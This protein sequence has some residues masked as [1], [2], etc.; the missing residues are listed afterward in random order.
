MVFTGAQAEFR[1]DTGADPSRATLYV[2]RD[3]P[4]V[5]A[6]ELASAIAAVPGVR[7]ADAVAEYSSEDRATLYVAPCA[8]LRELAALASCA[9]GDAFATRNAGAPAPAFVRGAL[10]TVDTRRDPGGAERDG[11]FATPG[12]LRRTDIAP[13]S[14]SAF[15]RADP[16]RLDVIE[17]VRNAAADVDPLLRV[18]VL[19]RTRTDGQFA[20]LRRAMLA[21]ASIVIGLIGLSLLL[22]ALE[23]L[24]ERRRLLAV[25]VAFGTRRS[26]LSWSLLWQSAVPIGLGLSIAVLTG[27]GL[28]AVLLRIIGAGV[29]VAWADVAAMVV[30]GGAV[31][32]LVT[33]ASLPVLWRTMRPEGLR[34]E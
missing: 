6:G 13:T 30:A 9:E 31:A 14:V 15:V 32:L 3:T 25:L 1:E 11:V 29:H 19:Q 20:T 21:G 10:R 4:R 7:S 34:T 16:R 24:R 8:T 17:R 33:A 22:T 23:Q 28:G 26:T 12:A 2:S 27:L 5:S 18:Y